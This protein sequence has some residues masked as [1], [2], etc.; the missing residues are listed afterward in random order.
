MSDRGRY[1]IEFRSGAFFQSLDAKTGGPIVT[2]QRFASRRDA[3]KLAD[4]H[5]WIWANGGCVLDA[6]TI[7]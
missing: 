5:P 6:D 4:E 2:A 7:G 1:V 3:T